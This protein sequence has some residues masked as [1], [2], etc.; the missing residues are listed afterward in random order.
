MTEYEI[1]CSK[2]GKIDKVP[3]KPQY[4]T[5]LLCKEC[6]K[7]KGPK[8]TTTG[9]ELAPIVSTGEGDFKLLTPKPEKVISRK[10]VKG[11]AY[12][13]DPVGL[14]VEIYIDMAPA[15]GDNQARMDLMTLSCDLVKQAQKAFE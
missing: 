14:A 11:S 2:C 1:T 7:N 15:T 9:E 6:Y 10:P 4:D 8:S 13:K 5:G 3:F 12:E